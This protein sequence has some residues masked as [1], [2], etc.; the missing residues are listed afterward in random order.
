MAGARPLCVDLDGTLIAGDTLV[1]SLLAFSR[2]DPLAAWR[3]LA[4]LARGR[5]H[6]K[7]RLAER[8]SLDV[9]ALPYRPEVLD[10]L[11]SQRDEGRELVL[12]TASDRSIAEEV[13]GH[14]GLFDV[15]IASD[16]E[17]NLKGS[18]KRHALE[19]RFGPGGYDYLGDSRADLP[20]W[21]GA[22]SASL[23]APSPRL[24]ERVRASVPVERTFSGGAGVAPRTWF[25]ALRIHQWVKNTLV[26]VPIVTAHRITDAPLL[27]LATVAF[28]CLG[29]CASGVYLLNDLIDLPEDRRHPTKRRRPL[30]AGSVPLGSALTAMPLLFAGAF[31]TSLLLLP[32]GF[33]LCLGVYV[34][35][36]LAY[37]FG[38]RALAIADVLLLAGLY[39]LRVIAGALAVDLYI[40]PWFVGFALFFF[41]N[42][43]FLKRYAELR[44]LARS[45]S[46]PPARRAY[47]RDDADLLLSLGPAA[48][49]MAVVVLA[50]YVSSDEVTRLYR[51][52][53]ILWLLAP[54]FVYWISRLWLIA[55]RGDMHDDPILFTL[56]DL[57]SYGV[58][59]AAAGILLLSALL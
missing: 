22:A 58:G 57:Q 31:A 19:S 50:L 1:E 52:P 38:V 27:L 29:L 47:Q 11:R 54:V 8:A 51:S 3:A 23:F 12:A 45:G 5:A 4:W 24:L 20:V 42:L 34:V 30:A 39:C 18:A 28:L 6:L 36:N 21:E 35:A 41:L 15:V 2:E 17:R 32:A 26:F 25:R 40:S 9:A 44:L 13:A 37:T 53:E 56:R 10:Y 16:G 59:A 46:E 49:Y 43:A 14:L 48:G 7:R 33:T 55:R